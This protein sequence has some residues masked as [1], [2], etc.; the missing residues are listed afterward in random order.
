M[1]PLL[2]RLFRILLPSAV[3]LS[4]CGCYFDRLTGKYDD[5]PE[6]ESSA[7]LEETEIEEKGEK[8]NLHVLEE[9]EREG[10]EVY[11]INSGDNVAITVYNHSDLAVKTTVTPDGYVGMVFIGQVKVAGLTLEQA[12]RLIEEK[13]SKYI[14]NPKVGISPYEIRSETVTIAGAVTKPGMYDI[15]NGM[16]LADLFAKAGGASTRF[17]DGQTLDATDLDKSVFLRHN[18]II[19]VNFQRAIVTGQSPYNVLLRKGDYI[20]IAPR[21]DS[22]VYLVGDVKK[23]FRH[24]WSKNLGLLEM[25]SDAGWVNET[26]W[27]HIIII[28]GGLVHPKMYK[29]DLDGI[30]SGKKNN[31]P[32]H[33]G[34]IVYVPHDNISEYNVFVRKLLPTGELLNMLTTPLTWRSTLGL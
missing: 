21:E 2:R 3:L 19:P 16:R 13:L 11:T 8:E 5:V 12:T 23:P 7:L 30:L 14:R 31:I 9:L 25:L 24:I 32:L 1:T 22:M 34:D 6:L 33:P 15:S 4:A 28:R 29:V 18:K 20:Y 10:E 26:R 27:S 17:Y